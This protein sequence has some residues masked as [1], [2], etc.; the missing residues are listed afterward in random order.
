MHPVHLCVLKNHSCFFERF[1]RIDRWNISLDM[2][3]ASF[4]TLGVSADRLLLYYCRTWAGGISAA[5][6]V[7]SLLFSALP[8]LWDA[9]RGG[10]VS[11]FFDFYDIKR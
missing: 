11:N 3:Y 9:W 4:H 2:Q 7:S 10:I 5:K 8:R 1:V 6:K